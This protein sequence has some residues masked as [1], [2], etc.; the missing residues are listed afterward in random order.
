MKKGVGQSKPHV[1]KLAIMKNTSSKLKRISHRI[2]SKLEFSNI[3]DTPIKIEEAG[4]EVLMH[5]EEIVFTDES[6]KQGSSVAF[7]GGHPFNDLS[8]S[9]DGY[10]S[11]GYVKSGKIRNFQKW[12]NVNKNN[13]L[14]KGFREAEKIL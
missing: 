8:E 11:A 9:E 3:K 10:F 2:A 13:K 4:E 6:K 1:A 12:Q 14:P 7:E 5:R